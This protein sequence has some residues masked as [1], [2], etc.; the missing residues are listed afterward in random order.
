MVIKMKKSRFTFLCL[1]W[2][3][4]IRPYW[5]SSDRWIALS[6]LAGHLVLMGSFIA[7][8]VRLSY[9]SNDFY[10]ALQK[11]DSH[12]FMHLLSI[13]AMYACLAIITFMIKAYLLQLLEIRWRQ[14]MTKS[15][16]E[17]WTYQRRYYTLQ[18]QGDGTDNPDQRI[19]DDILLFVK[20]TLFI[21]LGLFEQAITLA[22][23]LGILWCL[24]GVLQI[25]LGSFTLSIP[26]YMCWGALL[27]A[28]VG[29]FISWYLGQPLIR[30][31]YENEKREANFRYSLVRFRENVEGI[32]LYQGETQ[33][34]HIF[35]NRFL[36][37]VDNCYAVVKRMMIMNSWKSFYGQFEYIFPYLLAAPSLFAK[38]IT[39][40]T[41]MQTG[42]V[43]RHVSNALSFIVNNFP[44]IASWRATTNRLLE[45]K[46]NLEN[47]TPATLIHRTHDKEEIYVSC[48]AISL[49][50]GVILSED[51]ELCFQK[52]EHTL[53]MG[54][55]GIGKSTLARV[56]AG[57]WA[58][59]KGQVKVP[60]SS[61]LFLPQKPYMP[62][63]NLRFVLH[64]P[65]V[66][67]SIQETEN[68]LKAVGLEAFIPRLEEVNDWGRVLSLGEQQRIAIARSLLA[69]PQWLFLD[70]ATSAMD[71]RVEA[72]LYRTLKAY[73]PDT[74]LISIGH[75]D[76]LKPLHD[77][78]IYLGEKSSSL[79]KA[80]A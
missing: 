20:T 15:F 11:L 22:S 29:T 32:A 41:F 30:L 10:T 61:F 54:A 78:E 59:G 2:T 25:P 19:A 73:L 62:L 21:I 79:E 60:S 56:I 75:R 38:E 31:D 55:T 64:Y 4:L 52:N 66:N 67:A 68:V 74:T 57:L 76:S 37:I 80:V 63:G 26:G 13:F 50:H 53:I 6:L 71:E 18:L 5:T 33:E 70:E 12:A 51:I 46:Q 72:Q 49:P 44:S 77:R 40:G 1:L 23:F 24:S 7:I 3:H 58:Y 14:W 69:K 47:L 16:I 35:A 45:F 27:Y 17:N 8:S 42:G 48:E 39:L 34:K 9:W 65:L 36:H 43:F 28:T